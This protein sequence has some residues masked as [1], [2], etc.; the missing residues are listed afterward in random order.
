LGRVFAVFPA[1]LHLD[2]WLASGSQHR[3]WRAVV[4]GLRLVEAFGRVAAEAERSNQSRPGRCRHYQGGEHLATI[5]RHPAPGPY[6]RHLAQMEEV[7]AAILD[8]TSE[9]AIV[10]EM[11]HM[12]G[13]S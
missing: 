13:S 4:E 5:K 11:V 9:E 2:G 6:R 3:R 1:A 10:Y 12:L 8:A 7:D